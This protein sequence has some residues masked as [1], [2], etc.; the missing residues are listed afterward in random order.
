MLATQ[1]SSIS[2][3]EYLFNQSH[4]FPSSSYRKHHRKGRYRQQCFPKVER[5]KGIRF[6]AN[7][8]ANFVKPTETTL[9]TTKPRIQ[10]SAKALSQSFRY[11]SGKKRSLI[12]PLAFNLTILVCRSI[13]YSSF[14]SLPLFLSLI[15]R[16]RPVACAS[17]VVAMALSTESTCLVSVCAKSRSCSL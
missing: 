4:V 13:A 1:R 5:S 3:I 15:R 10:S 11:F 6:V 8:K 7:T 16:R 14:S 9:Q 17:C 2:I 12:H